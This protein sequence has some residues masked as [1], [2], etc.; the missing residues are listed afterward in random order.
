M[1]ESGWMEIL[2]LR[3]PLITIIPPSAALQSN[4]RQGHYSNNTSFYGAH[5]P[6]TAGCGARTHWS[7][8][9]LC[10]FRAK[11]AESR[12]LRLLP[13]SINLDVA[14][15]FA[16]SLAPRENARCRIPTLAHTTNGPALLPA[17]NCIRPACWSARLSFFT[18]SCVERHFE[19]PLDIIQRSYA[20]YANCDARP[21]R[22]ESCVSILTLA[23][24]VRYSA[25]LEQTGS[26]LA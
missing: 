9:C 25:Q 24:G 1:A 23:K 10:V 13:D 5:T 14:H 7:R 26:C 8:E 19:P 4:Y 2:S 12:R 3:A 22:E 18:I 6:T 15:L 17:Q 20:V 21:H 16:L 11:S